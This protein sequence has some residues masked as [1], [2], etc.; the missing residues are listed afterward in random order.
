MVPGVIS[1]K[2]MFKVIFNVCMDSSPHSGFEGKKH[3]SEEK[4]PHFWRKK[5]LF[6]HYFSLFLSDKMS[7]IY[8]SKSIQAHNN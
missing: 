4:N 3:P 5:A 6:S 7:Y 8:M 2:I 1:H